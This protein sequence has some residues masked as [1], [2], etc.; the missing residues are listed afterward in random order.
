MIGRPKFRVGIASIVFSVLAWAQPAAPPAPAQP[1]AQPPATAPATAPAQPA[2]QPPATAPATAPA[3]P[4]AGALGGLN[5][6]N[7]SLVEVID[8]LAQKLKINYIL[9]PKVNGKVTINTYGEI[10]QVDVRQLLDTILRINGAVMVK[11]GD[12]YRIVP[13][14]D[15]VKLPIS[16]RVAGGDLPNDEEVVL[17]LVFL[18]Y[19]SVN[20]MR[21]LIDPFLGEGKT[22]VVYEAANLLIILD[23]ARNMRRTMELIALFDNDSFAT[24]RV[25]L[26]QVEHGRPSDMVKELDTVFKAFALSEKSSGV[27]FMPI[28]RINTIIAVAP[29]PAV[30]D[31]VQKWIGRLDLP[32][33]VTAGSID[34]Y[35]YRLK[36]GCAD[37]VAM[38]V[39]QLY[40]A[41]TGYQGGSGYGGGFGGQGGGCASVLGGGPG[42]GVGGPGTF[43]NGGGFG[44]GGYGGGGYGGGGY[45]GGYGGGGYGGGYGAYGGNQ[46]GGAYNAG[47]Y[48]VAPQRAPLAPGPGGAPAAGTGVPGD[49]TGSY[50]GSAAAVALRAPRIIPNPYDNTILVQGTPQEWEQIKKLLEQIDIPPRQVLIDAKIYS[51]TLTGSFSAGVNAA[52]QAA[53]AVPG[54]SNRFFPSLVTTA[55]GAAG[56]ASGGISLTASALVGRNRQLLAF[57]SATESTSRTKV[58]SA[59][60]VIATDSIQASI[61][62]GTSV[63]TLSSQAVGA[64]VQVGGNSVFTNTVSNVSTGVTLSILARVNPSGIVTMVINQQVSD[65]VPPST[66]AAIQSP[67]F[68]Q[69]NVSTQV[70]VQDGDTVAIGGIIQETTGE[71]SSGIPLLHRVPV[72][73]ALF[74]SKSYSKDRTELV[75]FL[76]PRVI[77]DTN[78]IMEATQELKDEMQKLKK[79]YRE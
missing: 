54:Q 45:G 77:Y 51:V 1:A 33:K 56:A 36:Y 46:Y 58:I 42:G 27:K 9:D 25:R 79:I 70:T 52:F 24:K 7:V 50:L 67:S 35:L 41:T 74:G 53:T 48:A 26:F 5:F 40:G 30:F 21:A 28:D 22:L 20:D 65:P 49:L 17:N 4:A 8:I 73:G 18:K 13:A 3:A 62:V 47:G 43:L 15:A 60:S 23:N 71:S 59:P 14:A 75:I 34:N 66:G 63:P 37:T 38:S 10:K 31:E 44:G 2:A 6:Y 29:N 19:A 69:K 76:T 78:Q 12:L 16:P 72:V 55:V 57:L 11:V 64:G 39:M 68:S 32:Q 61:N